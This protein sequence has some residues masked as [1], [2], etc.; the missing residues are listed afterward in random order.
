MFALVH[1]VA[2]DSWDWVRRV[3]DP[4]PAAQ[5]DLWLAEQR[6]QAILVQLDYER[7]GDLWLVRGPDSDAGS[8]A[9]ALARARLTGQ[10][11]LGQVSVLGHDGA[12][13]SW[14][15]PDRRPVLLERVSVG[16]VRAVLGNYASA[17]PVW[18]A[19]TMI[20]LVLI[21]AFSAL[22]FTI[23]SRGNR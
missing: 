5:L 8:I 4:R 16:N 21:A 2:V 22:S 6:G 13:H 1:H 7:P 23:R 18:F 12:W 11:P 19:L 10:G 14:S 9:A 3:V 15:A 17:A 20:V